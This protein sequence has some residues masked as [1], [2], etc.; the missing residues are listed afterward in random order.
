[1]HNYDYYLPLKA[2][3]IYSILCT[4]MLDNI[5]MYFKLEIK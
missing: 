1:M 4:Q 2:F 3:K 5:T